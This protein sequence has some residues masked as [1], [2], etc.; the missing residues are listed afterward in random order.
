[1]KRLLLASVA[2]CGGLGSATLAADFPPYAPPPPGPA[3]Y[4]VP[5]PVVPPFNWSGFYVGGNLGV[6]FNNAGSVSDTFGSTFGT[7]NNTQFLVGGQVGVNYEFLGGAVIGAEAM[8]EGL[9]N[10]QNTVTV[11]NGANTASVTLGDR[12]PFCSMAKAALL[13]LEQAVRG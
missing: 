6:G 13:G 8:F 5:G 9:P 4:Y 3:P 7:T 10:T 12:S 2:L 1:M 11:T